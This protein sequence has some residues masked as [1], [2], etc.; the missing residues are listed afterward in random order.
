[1]TVPA[2]ASA[3]ADWMAHC[4]KLE[5]REAC[6]R[7]ATGIDWDQ[8]L[9]E[10]LFEKFQKHPGTSQYTAMIRQ[11][12]RADAARELRRRMESFYETYLSEPRLDDPLLAES[13]RPV[14]VVDNTGSS[15]RAGEL[16]GGKKKRAAAG[17]PPGDA[18]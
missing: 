6:Y 4:R 15:P 10:A 11:L 13:L 9:L 1:M 16:A 3:V 2:A 5:E 7:E 8:K 14:L 17:R 12:G 18:A